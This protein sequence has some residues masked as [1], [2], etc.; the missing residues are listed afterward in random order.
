MV[1]IDTSKESLDNLMAKAQLM[2]Q[3]DTF[4]ISNEQSA[5]LLAHRIKLD[6]LNY[7]IIIA[8]NPYTK[9]SISPRLIANC[10]W[11]KG[12]SKNANVKVVGG[13]SIINGAYLFSNLYLN[14]LDLSQLDTSSMFSMTSMFQD[15]EITYLDLEGFD[16][17][18]VVSM[19]CMFKNA[20]VEEFDLSS[21]DVRAVK[22]MREMFY[23]F[24]SITINLDSLCTDSVEDMQSM[25]EEC[26]AEEINLSNFNTTNVNNMSRM[27]YS[28]SV[29]RL[30]LRH[31]DTSHTKFMAKMF[32][33]CKASEILVDS[34]NVTN[35][36]V[37]DG[38][39]SL[40]DLDELDLSS[41]NT[42]S[43][44]SCM[45]MFASAKIHEL[46]FEPNLIKCSDISDMFRDFYTVDLDFSNVNSYTCQVFD[47]MFAKARIEHLTLGNKFEV[48]EHTRYNYMFYEFV[49]EVNIENPNTYGVYIETLDDNEG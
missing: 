1:K 14:E 29:N 20:Y 22:T 47:R 36:E 21:F 49:G 16:T 8:D 18:N 25:F 15:S 31:F 38:M 48:T 12:I 41:W 10:G 7:L 5:G 39:F 9:F 4:Q 27:F 33:D 19:N 34:W 3:L 17:S 37:M 6:N 30:D 13:S 44:D 42:R 35:V 24:E 32:C 46:K 2:N 11:F 45:D 23:A 28:C 26:R 43:L 40:V